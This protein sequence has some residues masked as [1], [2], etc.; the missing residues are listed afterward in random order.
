MNLKML[1]KKKPELEEYMVLLYIKIL[2]LSKLIYS[3][4]LE[5]GG[6]WLKEALRELGR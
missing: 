3:E 4:S 2:E 5:L 6:L 1:R